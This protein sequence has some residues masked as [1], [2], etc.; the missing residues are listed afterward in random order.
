[1]KVR[2]DTYCITKKERWAYFGFSFGQI[3][4]YTT[5]AS[6]VQIFMTDRGISAAAVGIILLL[7]R[8]W[9]AVNDPMFGVIV[10][11]SHLKGGKYRPWLKLAPG[12]IFV[13]TIL[14]FA[15]PEGIPVRVKTVLA[16]MFYIG[17]GM[18]YTVSDVPYFSVVSVMSGDVAERDNTMSRGRLFT[19]LGSALVTV[20]M[21]L[22]YPKVGW[23]VAA[24][25][26]A[27]AALF[28]M[29]PFGFAAKERFADTASA[30]TLKD[31]FSALFSNRYLVILCV[32][33]LVGNLT[34]TTTTI[35]GYFAIY[36]LGGAEKIPLITTI[37]LLCSVV[38]VGFVPLLI[39]RFDKF[40]LYLA[41]FGC[42]ILAS[43]GIYLT[44]YDNLML[45]VAF[46]M[47]RTTAIMFLNTFIALFIVDCAEYSRYKTGKDVTAASVSLQTF[48]TKGISAISAAVGMGVLGLAGFVDGANAVQPQAV[49]DTLFFLISIGPVI[50]LVP[51][52]V[53]LLCGYKLR[54]RYVQTMALVNRGELDK[55]KAQELLPER[56]R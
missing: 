6:F 9:D 3:I 13:F 45:F 56:L 20:I 32:G 10:T 30:V 24:A 15:L 5:M 2:P 47:V 26:M 14:L 1:M 37:L 48:T 16:A 42:A 38:F 22:M 54:D 8:I 55:E 52:F 4:F 40:H 33:L 49:T 23:F 34:N 27:V 43:I 29:Q 12:L 18:S 25:C 35:S 51:G 7:A 11:R 21:P 19:M 17:W 28:F 41:C 44:G 53:I 46:S 31:I 36:N 39:R 50:G